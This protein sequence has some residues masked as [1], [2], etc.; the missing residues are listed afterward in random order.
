MLSTFVL[1]ELYRV[2]SLA[3]SLDNSGLSLYG[4]LE[5]IGRNGWRENI[6]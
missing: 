1:S 3:H 5:S 4:I 6:D 2:P